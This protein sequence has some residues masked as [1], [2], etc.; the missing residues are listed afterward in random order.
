MKKRIIA[1]LIFIVLIIIV[2][3]STAFA[4]A[5]S[6]VIDKDTLAKG[7]DTLSYTNEEYK[8]LAKNK[9]QNDNDQIENLIIG[10]LA[11]EKA[12]VRNPEVY[13]RAVVFV[14]EK[15]LTSNTIA[16]RES[17]SRYLQELNNLM[18][19][20]IYEDFLSFSQYKVTINQKMACASI[21]EDY[22]YF[23]NDGFDGESYRRREYTFS[24]SKDSGFW[25]IV[26][27][28]TNDPWET[29][30]NFSYTE[31]DVSGVIA[32]L[33]DEMAKANN[34]AL[35]ESPIGELEDKGE[36]AATSLNHWTYNPNEAITYAA[37]HYNDTSNS[38]FGYT[39][40]NDCQNFASQCVWAGLGGSGSS[41]SDRPA[42]SISVA[43]SDGPNVWQRNAYTTCYSL[44][45]TALNWSW[46]NTCGFANMLKVSTPTL[47]GPYGNTQYSGYF[48]Y[49]NAGNVL[50]ADWNGSPARDTLDHAMF[51]TH[52]SGTSG[53]RTT[54]QVKIAAHSGETNTAY[55]ILSSY[56]AAPASYFA[57]VV[58]SCGYYATTQ[59]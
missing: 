24:L 21:V 34:T 8:E 41:T 19:W 17:E 48:G 9:G 43:G 51:V 55:Q 57:R 5:N 14:D 12:Y 35:N 20:T 47:E 23:I 59:S 27:I 11:T 30:D 49:A 33:A 3:C 4:A 1:K 32:Q 22:K 2:F 6:T 45:N 15:A 26:D 18:G 42:V 28:K 58:I 54:S 53:S 52:V 10:Y 7:F 29:E 31:I 56:T 37:N 46:D 50:E 44:I 38:V 36:K 40:G 39:E 16:Y 13:E 25:T